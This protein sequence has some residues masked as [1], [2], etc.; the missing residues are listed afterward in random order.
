MVVP[1]YNVERYL[2]ECLDSLLA[3]S[4]RDFEAILVIDGATDH[5]EQIARRYAARDRRIRLH[6][7]PNSGLGA[8]RN[9]GVRQAHG[10]FM[11]FLDSDDTLPPDAYAD[12]MSTI[13]RTGSDMVVGT[14][15]RGDGDHWRAMPLMHRNHRHRREAVALADMPLMLADVF[16]VNK[17][18]RRS[19][20]DEARLEFPVGMR[21]EDQPTLTRAFVAARQFDV[22]CESVYHWRV[23][24][25]GTSLTQRRHELVDLVDRIE[26]KRISTAIMRTAG[27]AQVADVWFR[28]ILPV[29]M[30]EYFRAVP[31]CSQEYWGLLCS[32]VTEFWSNELSFDRT[33]VPVQQR[34]MGW[35]VTNA[36]RGELE[37][38]IRF[39]DERRGDIPLEVHEDRVEA[40]LPG[41]GDDGPELP[42]SVYVLSDHER[43]W[44]CRL[45]AASWEADELC[46]EGF[47]LIHNVP[48]Q[49]VATELRGR[50]AE[51]TVDGWEGV[52][53]PLAVRPVTQPG[54]AQIVGRPA[55]RYEE[56]GFTCTI[57][58]ARVLAEHPDVHTWRVVFERRIKG[59]R[60]GGSV[61]DLDRDHVDRS[62]REVAMSGEPPRQARLLQFEDQLV[63]ET[64]PC[65]VVE[66]VETT[67][68][69][70]W[71]ALSRPLDPAPTAG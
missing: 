42:Q 8:A 11:A 31:G 66:P 6:R 21:Y 19:F 65:P 48:T 70:A 18:F 33:S 22:I 46:I 32:A 29:D 27:C 63:L 3:Q 49:G 34:L 20:W 15:K 54:A 2:A 43:R 38:L 9:A 30:W 41:V 16:P 14:L 61:T 51:I 39:I 12:M 52:S 37:R 59:I 50:L 10:E 17:I 13:D 71:S 35:L 26:S 45:I 67:R 62:W 40:L 55:Q 44:D 5:S 69:T 25:D 28:E 1:V 58:V 68:P 4:F 36:R 47:A 24:A 60:G 64:L 7:Q 56:C 57:D 23:R 53:W